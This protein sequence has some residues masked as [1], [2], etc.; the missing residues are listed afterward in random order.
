ME[1]CLDEL[2]GLEDGYRQKHRDAKQVMSCGRSAKPTAKAT[3]GNS[4]LARRVV[5]VG[6]T[7]RV[8]RATEVSRASCKDAFSGCFFVNL[9]K[10]VPGVQEDD[11][12]IA[13][14][15]V[16]KVEERASLAS[17]LGAREATNRAP[18]PFFSPFP[19]E[20]LVLFF[21]PFISRLISPA[22]VP[23]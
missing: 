22:C 1:E 3:R 6:Q 23:P 8:A 17:R 2:R 12:C 14:L 5:I 7:P 18:V 13:A 21:F 20:S 15:Y 11:A 9:H 4:G 10:N 19:E 16:R